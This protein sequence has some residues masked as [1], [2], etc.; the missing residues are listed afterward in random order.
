MLSKK[1]ITRSKLQQCHAGLNTLSGLMSLGLFIVTHEMSAC[2]LRFQTIFAPKSKALGWM[3]VHVG[4]DAFLTD[5]C[6]WA[7]HLIDS[8]PKPYF[9]E[10]Q[11]RGSCCRAGQKWVVF[12]GYGGLSKKNHALSKKN[13]AQLEV[14]D[15][16]WH[17]GLCL[18]VHQVAILTWFFQKKVVSAFTT[19]LFGFN[20]CRSIKTGQFARRVCTKWAFAKRQM[21]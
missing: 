8:I 2:S 17:L 14:Q 21:R 4:T 15:E 7:M 13:Q 9:W 16:S 18:L 20:W 6:S 10:A 11:V 12:F 5:N 3:H 19:R 1:A